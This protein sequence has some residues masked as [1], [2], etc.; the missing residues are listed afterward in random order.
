M[1]HAFPEDELRPLSC[2]PLTRNRDDPT[3]IEVNDALGNYSLT[4]IDSLSTLAILASSTK[5]GHTNKPLRLFQD[6]VRDIVE[7]YGDGTSGSAGQGIRARGF[8]LDSKVQVFETAIRGLGGLLSAHQFAVG[9]LPIKGYVPQS[10]E[11][12]YARLWRKENSTTAARGIRWNNGFRYDGQL[13]RLAYDLGQRL[14]PAFW[15]PT[16]IPYPRVNLRDGIPFYVNSPRGSQPTAGQCSSEQQGPQEITETCSAGAGSLVLEFTVLSRLT[17]DSRFEDLAKR[18]FWAIWHRRSDID[19]IGAGIDAETGSWIHSYTGIGAGIDS[20]FEYAFKSSILLSND[21]HPRYEDQRYEDDPR[22]LF[23]PLPAS[24]HMPE[25]FAEAWEISHTAINRQLLRTLNFQHPHYIQGDLFTGAARAFWIDALSAYYP[26]LLTLAGYVE[27][28]IEAHLLTT[29]LWDRFAALPERWNVATG[30]VE[31]GL[32]WWVGRPEFIESNYYLYRATEDPW[33]LYVGE[34]TLRDIQRRCWTECGWAGIQ[35]VLTGEQNDR[36]E[37][38]FLGETAKYLFLL[39]DQS[40]PLNHLDS[41]F[42]FTTEGHPL[43]IPSSS[44]MRRSSRQSQRSHGASGLCEA[45]LPNLPFTLSQTAA[46]GDVYHAGSL[47]RLHLL[48]PRGPAESLAGEQTP[49]GTSNLASGAA[50]PSNYTYF[51]WTLPPEMIPYDAVSS[52]MRMA[53]T[54]DISFPTM[55]GNDQPIPPLQRVNN[56]ILINFLGGLRL[57]MIQDDPYWADGDISY[58]YRIHAINNVALGKDEKVYL[59]RD[60]GMSILNPIDPYF[61]RIQDGGSLDLVL[62]FGDSSKTVKNPNN[63]SSDIVVDSGGQADDAAASTVRAAWNSLV[64]Q[65]A[66]LMHDSQQLAFPLSTHGRVIEA[67]KRLERLSLAAVIP[68]GIG[69]AALP[70]WPEAPSQTATGHA[71]PPLSWNKIYTTDDLCDRKLPL[72]VPRLHQ[73]IVIKRGKCSFSQKLSNIPL[74]SPSSSSLQLVII[75]NY[76]D[77]EDET[78][79]EVLFRPLLDQ[80]QFSSSGLPRKNPVPMVMVGGGVQTYQALESARG[81]GVKRRYSIESQGVPITNLIVV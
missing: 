63:T 73:V 52:M 44:G 31:G 17:G 26:G 51:P 59:A 75:V 12:E 57:G 36:M 41:P 76:S 60:T 21:F 47:A 2:Q 37:S 46:R 10:K 65:I 69:A 35:D 43:I 3:H 61:T 55:P 24:D 34:M 80:I 28:A 74:F 40:H 1:R 49:D 16:G 45:K 32:G 54:S 29:A 62:E 64:S 20:F 38:F 4:L 56:G 7:Q 30:G 23:E 15:T 22:I 81:I 68:T 33:Y 78:G 11:T 6:G 77:G 70:D 50:S 9:D 79:E 39:F 19:L 72:S 25:T 14:L 42:V 71:Q 66:N 58:G 13:L 8:A 53:P 67:D 5:N 18:A 27:E 48:P